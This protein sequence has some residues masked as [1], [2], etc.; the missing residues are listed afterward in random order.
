M[1]IDL[2]RLPGVNEDQHDL[3]GLGGSEDVVAAWED[4]NR[5]NVVHDC[6]SPVWVRILNR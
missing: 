6:V 4:L 2:K 5:Y 1:D 3:A